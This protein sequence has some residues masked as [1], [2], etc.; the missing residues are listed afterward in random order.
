M[1]IQY[2]DHFTIRSRPQDLDA[3][4]DFYADVLGLRAG[5]RPGFGF[6]GYWMY[7]GDRPVVHLAGSLPADG[8][9]APEGGPGSTGRFDH[10]SFHAGDLDAVQMRLGALGISFRGSPV[11]GFDLYQIVIYDPAGVK[12]ELTFDV[13]LKGD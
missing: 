1:D 3:L 7:L 12:V 10:V 6:P 9:A 2:I 8:Q 13:A 11:P 4:H 5:R